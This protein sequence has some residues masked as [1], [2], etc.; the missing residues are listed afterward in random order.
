M[1]LLDQDWRTGAYPAGKI[2]HILI[3]HA[4]ATV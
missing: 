4:N 1:S 3:P 2:D